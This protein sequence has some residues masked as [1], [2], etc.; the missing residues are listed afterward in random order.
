MINMDDKVLFYSR[1]KT[2]RA[3]AI[4]IYNENTFDFET[5]WVPML[6]GNRITLKGGPEN[7]PSKEEAVECARY[8]RDDCK[9]V[10]KGWELGHATD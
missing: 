2:P 5:R 9:K 8:I 6:R 1:A 4:T 10:A 7:Y 3:K